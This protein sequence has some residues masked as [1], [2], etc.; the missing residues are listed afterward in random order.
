MMVCLNLRI[1]GSRMERRRV[2]TGY[3]LAV[4]SAVAFSAKG[5]FAKLLYARGVDPV[6]LLAIRFTLALP[7]FWLTLLAFPGPRPSWRETAILAASGVFGYYLAAL[8][9]FFGLLYVDATVERVILYTYPAMVVLLTAVFFKERLGGMRAA[10]VGVT[11]L[12]LVLLLE[13]WKGE[14]TAELFGVAL[15]F[16][17]AAIYA[18]NFIVTEVISRRVSGVRIAAYSVTGATVAF[19]GTWRGESI[20][21]GADVWGLFL[22]LAVISTYAPV[23]AFAMG[24]ERI[25]A[26][27]FA[28]VSFIG[29]VSTA[30]LAGVFLG[31]ALTKVEIT[32][33]AL[34]LSGVAVLSARGR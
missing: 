12:G 22:A 5:I 1:K 21:A 14:F 11:Y 23:V 10:A 9:D 7:L 17:A 26:R 6:S 33:M 31:E 29:P 34:V 3:L 4:A 2:I 16:A 28:V 25:G 32:G 20:P 18:V 27:R 30:L 24:V 13:V 15:V 8:A 19:L